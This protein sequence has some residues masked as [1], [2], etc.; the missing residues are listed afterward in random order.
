LEHVTL[1]G[2]LE[3]EL[4]CTGSG[5]VTL[6]TDLPGDTMAVQ[7]T[8]PI[9]QTT[10]R[11]VLRWRLKP[12]T[13]GRLYSIKVV[14]TGSSVIRLY[15]GR[16][17]ARALTV[18]PPSLVSPNPA[19]WQWFAI[20]IPATSEDWTA[21]PLPIPPTS[22]EWTPLPLPIPPTSEEWT[23]TPLPIKATPPLPDW[24]DIPVDQ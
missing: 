16:L 12:G 15:A 14:P 10:S 18:S 11:R 1:F 3:L 4:H 13:K 7:E 17:W 23:E 21:V 9:P 6:S 24:V 2:I 8:K 19:V 5:T 20:D 22:E